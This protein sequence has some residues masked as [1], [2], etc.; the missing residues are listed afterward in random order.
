MW[1][2]CGAS[3]TALAAGMAVV[4]II[5]LWVV[6]PFVLRELGEDRAY[7]DHP[8]VGRQLPVVRL[9]PLT[10][11]S[12]AVTSEALSGRVVLLHF[13]GT[14]CAPCRMEFPH[15]A[16]LYERLRS[17][18]GFLLLA[19][20]CGQGRHEDLESLREDTAAFLES[21]G[22]ELPT[23]ADPEGRTRRAFSEVAGSLVFPTTAVIDAQGTIRGVWLGF[24]PSF[25]NQIEALVRRL[26]QTPQAPSP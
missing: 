23:Y 20:S 26:L 11:S 2:S 9:L 14:W 18:P 8:A 5:V 12:P 21:V 22:H 13:W 1:K 3:R 10:G 19:V 17:H 15:L 24:N 7:E 6:A 4:A 25:P 16:E